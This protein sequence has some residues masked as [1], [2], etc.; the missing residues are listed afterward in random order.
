MRDREK[1]VHCLG[2]GFVQQ[3]EKKDQ[4]KHQQQSK[5]PTNEEEQKEVLKGDAGQTP[6]KKETQVT[7]EQS[8]LLR[9][10]QRLILQDQTSEVEQAVSILSALNRM[11]SQEE[12]QVHLANAYF[13]LHKTA[14]C[15]KT[16]E[17][18]LVSSPGNFHAQYLLSLLK[19]STPS[20][21][22]H[23]QFSSDT[24]IRLAPA[25]LIATGFSLVVGLI[26]RR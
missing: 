15:K 5:P 18:L 6:L 4:Q 21:H 2:C 1:R 13:K 10:A 11:S 19:T 22:S 14:E 25:I 17:D 9:E 24:I 8:S 20:A 3:E 16:C 26:L 7:N 12:Y 23:S